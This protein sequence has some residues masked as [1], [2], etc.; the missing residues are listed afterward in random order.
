MGQ[1]SN[2][3]WVLFHLP[4]LMSRQELAVQARP[5]TRTPDPLGG[6]GPETPEAAST[7][8]VKGQSVSS[9]KPGSVIAGG[10]T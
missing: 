4:S 8:S 9:Q 5:C 6:G 2:S 3:I 7:L 1:G 10:L